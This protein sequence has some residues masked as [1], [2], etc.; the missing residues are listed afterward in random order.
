MSA[1]AH[2]EIANAIEAVCL[3]HDSAE[4]MIAISMIIGG[5]A[6]QAKYPDLDGLM[7]LIHGT[8][9]ATFDLISEERLQ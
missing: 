5:F 4:V 3:G 7:S 2:Q 1:C 6:A 8:A 9:Q